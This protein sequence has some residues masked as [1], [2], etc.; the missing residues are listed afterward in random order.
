MCGFGYVKRME[1][2]RIVCFGLDMYRERKEIE[3]YVFV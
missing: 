1:G 3:L 2:N